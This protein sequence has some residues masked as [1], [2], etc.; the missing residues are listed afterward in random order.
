MEESNRE[1]S[2]PAMDERRKGPPQPPPFGELLLE[3]DWEPLG[4]VSPE[5]EGWLRVKGAAPDRR[6]QRA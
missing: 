2:K 3:A 5:V 6:K 4:P 1:V